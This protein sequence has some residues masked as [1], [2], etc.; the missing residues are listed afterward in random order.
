ME[1]LTYEEISD[2]FP[3]EFAAR[4]S[5]KLIYRYPSGES[6][7]VSPG[8]PES[9]MFFI[10]PSLRTWWP[11]WSLSWWSWRDKATFFWWLIRLFSDAF[12]LTSWTNLWSIFRTSKYVFEIEIL[13]IWV[14]LLSV[15]AFTH[16]H[17][18]HSSS[19]HLWGRIYTLSYRSHRYT[20]TQGSWI[21]LA[22]SLVNIFTTC[23]SRE[24]KKIFIR[25]AVNTKT[26][27]N[28]TPLFGRRSIVT[29]LMCTIIEIIF[30]LF[31]MMPGGLILTPSL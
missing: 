11:A 21:Y 16:P 6:Y 22:I 25:E 26:F 2:R 28:T 9:E 7:Q 19:L 5:N 23:S 17:Q 10:F 8:L 31:F 3:E 20:Q 4:D 30:K 27:G 1:G 29:F 14:I 12:W 24:R 18:T 13:I 15:G